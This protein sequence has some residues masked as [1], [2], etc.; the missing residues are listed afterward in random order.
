MRMMRKFT[1]D[2]VDM[3]SQRYNEDDLTYYQELKPLWPVCS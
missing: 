3:S 1:Y 2:E